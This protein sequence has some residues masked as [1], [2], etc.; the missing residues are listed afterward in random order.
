MGGAARLL[1]AALPIKWIRLFASDLSSLKYLLQI[2]VGIDVEATDLLFY[3]TLLRS[4]VP[5]VVV[6]MLQWLLEMRF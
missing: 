1:I 5:L 6:S 3:E 2:V 4:D